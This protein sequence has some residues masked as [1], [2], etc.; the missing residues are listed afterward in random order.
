MIERAP[1]W[2]KS[3]QTG[4]PTMWK[5]TFCQLMIA[6]STFVVTCFMRYATNKSK[7]TWFMNIFNAL[8]TEWITF[9]WCIFYFNIVK[10][11]KMEF[12]DL[13]GDSM[14]NDL[15]GETL[16]KLWSRYLLLLSAVKKI[17]AVFGINVL[18]SFCYIYIWLM[19]DIYSL[20][21]ELLRSE[22]DK[23]I[24]L[25]Y[26]LLIILQVFKLSILVYQP[27]KC[28]GYVRKFKTRIACYPSES[29][30][31]EEVNQFQLFFLS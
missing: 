29:S 14:T 27:P 3:H 20:V 23:M 28:L 6:S 2:S 26:V 18:F 25:T 11:A 30:H 9:C 17:N 12:K 13:Y 5:A 8:Y 10:G 22:P 16:R 24:M 19:S 15:D 7:L 4:N 31:L 21:S 1:R